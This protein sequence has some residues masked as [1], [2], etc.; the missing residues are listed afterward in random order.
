MDVIVGCDHNS[1]FENK[2][3]DLFCLMVTWLFITTAG[4]FKSEAQNLIR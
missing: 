1:I 2:K 4:G 3:V